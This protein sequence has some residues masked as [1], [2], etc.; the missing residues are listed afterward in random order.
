VQAGV[1]V[2]EVDDSAGAVGGGV[3]FISA[4]TSVAH[5]RFNLHESF[6]QRSNPFAFTLD[7]AQAGLDR[8]VKP[9]RSRKLISMGCR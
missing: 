5:T 9:T 8:H 2:Q 4:V 3:G 6:V 7:V 1:G